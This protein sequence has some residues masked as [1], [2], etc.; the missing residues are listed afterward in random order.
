M[1]C[2]DEPSWGLLK[3]YILALA[4]ALLV[5]GCGASNE[6]SGGSKGGGEQAS[7]SSGEE[8]SVGETDAIVWGTG[9]RGA[10]LAHG[11]AYDA[12]SWKDQGR[13]LAEN[14]VVA[15]AVEET[16]ASRA[17]LTQVAP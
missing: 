1:V 15:L 14:G 7:D 2:P 3:T 6:D 9:D 5:A 13:T 4:V 16:T 11:A 8:V 17:I 12:A 10:V